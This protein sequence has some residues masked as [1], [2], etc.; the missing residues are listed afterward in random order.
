[1][2]G[3]VKHGIKLKYTMNGWINND[4]VAF[5]IHVTKLQKQ[6]IWIGCQDS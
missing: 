1:M 3:W 6:I 2:N 5:G 4:A